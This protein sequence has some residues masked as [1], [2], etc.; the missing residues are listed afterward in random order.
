MPTSVLTETPIWHLGAYAK[1]LHHQLTYE[2]F[3]KNLL[4]AGPSCL[5][6][7][8]TLKLAVVGA[9]MPDALIVAFLVALTGLSSFIEYIK[10][11]TATQQKIEKMIVEIQSLRGEILSQ[12][13]QVKAATSYV[14]NMKLKTSLQVR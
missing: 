1:I 5:L 2:A 4:K 12:D 9:G 14:S 7:A 10:F 13:E 3:M 6:L 8:Y 11:E